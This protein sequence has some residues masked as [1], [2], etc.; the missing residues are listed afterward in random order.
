MIHAFRVREICGDIRF[1]DNDWT[2]MLYCHC[3]VF[4]V[5]MD[6]MTFLHARIIFSAHALFTRKVVLG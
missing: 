2:K 6:S 5:N 4:V 1:K 3:A